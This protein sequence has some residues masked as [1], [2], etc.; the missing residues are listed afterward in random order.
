LGPRFA[1]EVAGE[2]V[3]PLSV[4]ATTRTAAE[5]AGASLT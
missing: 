5:L 4:A 3:A 2:F 1:V